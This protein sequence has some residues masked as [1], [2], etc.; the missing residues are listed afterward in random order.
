MLV[1]RDKN[2]LR[3]SKRIKPGLRTEHRLGQFQVL[4]FECSLR[5]VRPILVTLACLF[6]RSSQ[7]LKGG[8]N[9]TQMA[10]ASMIKVGPKTVD[11]TYL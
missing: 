2:R 7:A 6:L 1:L 11:W 5:H 10:V 9:L 8:L 3:E 4:L